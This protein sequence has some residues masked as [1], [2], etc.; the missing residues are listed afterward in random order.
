VAAEAPAF[1]AAGGALGCCARA[2][3]AHSAAAITKRKTLAT[4]IPV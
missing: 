1:G 2:P 4:A 3:P